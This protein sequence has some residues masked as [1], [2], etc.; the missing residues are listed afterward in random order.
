VPATVGSWALAGLAGAIVLFGTLTHD[1]RDRPLV[2]D[3]ASH[4]MQA[5]SLAYG[6]HTLN[7][8]AQDYD[9]WQALGWRPQPVGLFFQR[10]EG[11]RWAAAKPYGYSLYAAPFVALLGPAR[12]FAVANSLLLV[13]LIGVSIAIL[14]TRYR[15]PPVALTV[16]A[17]Y[18][19]SYAYLY[20][21]VTLTELFLALLVLL[22]FG[23][24]LRYRDTGRAWWAVAAFALAGFVVAE[25]LAF[26]PLV[27]PLAAY[28]IWRAPSTK[29]RL[30]LP[31]LAVVTFGLGVLPYLEYSDWK[32]ITPYGGDRYYATESVPFGDAGTGYRRSNFGTADI[33][34]RATVR[35]RVLAA[36]FYVA[37]QHTGLLP[38]IPV[39]LF[40]LLAVIARVLR[41]D[42]W[43]LAALL[44]V[45]GA[46][47]FYVLLFPKNYY[48]GGQ[49][50]G[51]RYFLQ[52]APA[53]LVLAVMADLPR[54]W[55]TSASIAGILV[56]VA[57]IWPH[58]LHPSIAYDNLAKLSPLQKALPYESN[59][60]Y[61]GTWVCYEDDCR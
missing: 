18:L 41:L 54:R 34:R 37:G 1:F 31:V 45:V 23:A 9:R 46:I 3:E 14:R 49:S 7:F 28:A 30:A 20:A 58:H 12:G 16:T 19:A 55:V 56:A 32:S 40:L 2:G 4:V 48:G 11:N 6:N 42:G 33:D 5:L 21:Y 59:Q 51:N 13:V 47:L 8:D 39:A 27:A 50:L 25:K 22:I 29:L 43:T 44:G 10:Y 26:F 15:G 52:M 60:E 61:R 53:V 17:F 35:D 57:M 36:G 38:F 24:F